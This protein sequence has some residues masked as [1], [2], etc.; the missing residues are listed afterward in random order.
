VFNQMAET[1]PAF[2]DQTYLKLA[3]VHEQWPIVGRDDLYYGGTSYENAG[4]LGMQLALNTS[5]TPSTTRLAGTTVEFIRMPK[6]G[7]IAFPIARLYDRGKT[8]MPSQLLHERISEPYIVLNVN[9]AEMLRIRDGD[10]VHMTVVNREP[11]S[12]DRV[13]AGQTVVVQAR[14]DQELPERVV[15]VPRSFGIPIDKPTPVEIRRTE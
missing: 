15:L 7:Q 5:D 4:G 3:Q 1:V 11:N 6:L 2:S 14:L 8:L 10:V 12:P 9:D 13:T